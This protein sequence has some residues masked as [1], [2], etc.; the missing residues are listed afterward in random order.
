MHSRWVTRVGLALSFVALASCGGGGDDDSQTSFQGFVTNLAGTP[1][2]DGDPV[3][4][5]GLDFTF[6]EDPHAFDALF[7]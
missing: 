2:E 7:D 5:D 1:V 4:I 6:T 3:S